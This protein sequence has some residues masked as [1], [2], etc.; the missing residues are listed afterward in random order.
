MLA[1]LNPAMTCSHLARLVD[2]HSDWL[3]RRQ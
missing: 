3:P 2:W 1:I